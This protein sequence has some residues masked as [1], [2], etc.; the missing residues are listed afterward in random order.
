[1]V[2]QLYLI[3]PLAIALT[4]LRSLGYSRDVLWIQLCKEWQRG[5][6]IIK[7]NGCRRDNT[8]C[9]SNIVLLDRGIQCCSTASHIVIYP[10]LTIVGKEKRRIK[11]KYESSVAPEND[12][13]K[14]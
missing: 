11:G 14:H 13:A 4:A 9:D 5:R 1:M 12:G 10:F 7:T 2:V 3:V 8:P 6:R